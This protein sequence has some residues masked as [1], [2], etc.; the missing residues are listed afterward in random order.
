MSC[1]VFAGKNYSLLST[2]YFRAP[3][4]LFF[5]VHVQNIIIAYFFYLVFI[6]LFH[7]LH[8][9]FFFTPGYFHLAIVRKN[10]RTT[11]TAL[12]FLNMLKIYKEGFMNANKTAIF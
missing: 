6:E 10:D 7:L 12:V 1:F 4:Y 3:F 2:L 8:K 11:F 5:N 9:K